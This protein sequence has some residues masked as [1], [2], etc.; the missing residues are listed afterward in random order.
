MA[1]R[2]PC[3]K[4]DPARGQRTH[5]WPVFLPGG[6]RFLFTALLNDGTFQ[7]GAGS[8]DDPGTKWL[9]KVGSPVAYAPPGYLL[10]VTDRATLVADR[11]DS[12]ALRF[13]GSRVPI[14]DKLGPSFSV[15]QTGVLSYIRAATAG[16]RK[17]VWFD[18][19]GTPLERLKD[20]KD[21]EDIALS[22]DGSRLVI[23]AW[24]ANAG[25][26]NLWLYEVARAQ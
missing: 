14:T 3:T 25:A 10:T 23:S 17:L 24:D 5:G 6:R 21:P 22:P 16:P 7:L 2:A 4:L 15:S 13:L 11:F 8:L 9:G 1:S 20:E 18:R 19:T 26:P 12:D